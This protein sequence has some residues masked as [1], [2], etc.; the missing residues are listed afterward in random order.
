VFDEFHAIFY[1]EFAAGRRTQGWRKRQ[2]SAS[3]LMA[4]ECSSVQKSLPV[5]GEDAE[6]GADH[7]DWLTIYNF[8]RHIGH[9]HA[10]PGESGKAVA[11]GIIKHPREGCVRK[12][13]HT[14]L[15]IDQ[16]ITEGDAHDQ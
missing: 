14:V 8:N 10:L 9:A 4:F 16:E 15:P 11:E 3:V 2:F 5:E 13:M 12:A 7:T 1:K 6:T